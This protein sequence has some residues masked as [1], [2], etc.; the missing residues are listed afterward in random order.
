[1]S[2]YKAYN[3]FTNPVSDIFNEPYATKVPTLFNGLNTFGQIN[4][5][6]TTS[7]SGLLTPDFISGY[8]TSS[9]YSTIID[10]LNDNGISGWNT[11]IPLLLTHGAQD[12]TVFPLSTENIYSSMIAAGTSPEI[13]KKIIVAG[14]D[15]SEGTV[16]CL[17]SGIS[18][19]LNL[20]NSN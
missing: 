12:T 6:L 5:E 15:H 16:P 14:V 13:C 10:A 17:I 2:A 19:L 9:K 1:M 8:K 4:S 3:Q 20:K 18:F 7:I 11:G